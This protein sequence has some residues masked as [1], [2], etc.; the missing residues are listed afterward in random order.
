MARKILVADDSVVIQKSIGITFAQEDFQVTFVGNGEEAVQRASEL[1]PDLILADT[2]MP[3]LAGTELCKKLRQNPD[4]RKTPILLLSNAQENFNPA[5]LKTAGANDFIQKPFESNQLLEKV[6]NLFTAQ[7]GAPETSPS[8]SMEESLDNTFSK[9]P[10]ASEEE[11]AVSQPPPAPSTPFELEKSEDY[12][13]DA[14]SLQDLPS[15]SP[16]TLASLDVLSMD[17]DNEKSDEFVPYEEENTKTISAASAFDA[18]QADKV[19]SH[20]PQ[21]NQPAA[22]TAAPADLKLSEAQ[23]EQ[24]VSK[25]FQNV[26][27]RI[28]W[29]VVPE[30]AE[31]IIKEEIAKITDDK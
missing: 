10:F 24:I 25:V 1:K 21:T 30:M 9:N 7:A 20:D 27:E 2:S 12:M 11:T 18:A 15:P 31:R 14:M 13:P 23:I 3:K 26:I 4:L 16:N 17:D 19:P 8:I 6:K 22:A 5:Q 28:A 29:E